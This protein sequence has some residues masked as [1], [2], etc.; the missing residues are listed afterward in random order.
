MPMR[1]GGNW[2]GKGA[3]M[4]SAEPT[5]T[6]LVERLRRFPIEDRQ[7]ILDTLSPAERH[8]IAERIED[9]APSPYALDIAAR[10]AADADAAMTPA[11]REVL[12]R[13]ARRPLPTAMP[14][15]RG[16]TLFDRMVGRKKG[17]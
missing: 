2:R 4:A 9:R 15:T 1:C 11:T 17:R 16:P 7:A 13:A 10:I 12:A 8:R 3:A 5:L 14:A 6:H